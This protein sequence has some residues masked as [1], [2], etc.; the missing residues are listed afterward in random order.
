MLSNF[1]QKHHVFRQ[2]GFAPII[3]LLILVSGI[4][5]TSYLVQQQTNLFPK[6]AN[7]KNFQPKKAEKKSAKYNTYKTVSKYL[8]VN[9]AITESTTQLSEAKKAAIELDKLIRETD[10]LDIKFNKTSDYLQKKA[11]A[12][13]IKIKNDQVKTA[14]DNTRKE[15]DEADISLGLQ[16][17]RINKLKR[18]NSKMRKLKKDV[19]L[20]RKQLHKSLL[21][22]RAL[23]KINQKVDDK[24]NPYLSYQP[25]NI[26]NLSE[27]G[28]NFTVKAIEENPKDGALTNLGAYGTTGEFA[29]NDSIDRDHFG[30]TDQEPENTTSDPTGGSNDTVAPSGQV[31]ASTTTATETQSSINEETE[32]AVGQSQTATESL[33]SST[34][35]SMPDGSTIEANPDG[36]FTQTNPDGTTVTTDYPNGTVT[37]SAPGQEPVTLSIEDYI[38]GTTNQNQASMDSNDTSANTNT[39][40]QSGQSNTD[41]NQDK[42][43]DSAFG[44]QQDDSD[45]Q[46]T[47]SDNPGNE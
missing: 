26:F 36:S 39:T 8:T 27:V 18:N 6:A 28:L 15:L 9:Q 1:Y 43:E 30:G 4:L 10:A 24:I 19:K 7:K 37:V 35:S 5:T 23:E 34:T 32:Q 40:D 45:G 13:E 11:L 38:N 2:A 42:T 44:G 20:V 14:I 17:S 3:V 47:G 16:N 21:A 33:P 31:V 12:K 46:S 29:A 22:I 25:S 41:G